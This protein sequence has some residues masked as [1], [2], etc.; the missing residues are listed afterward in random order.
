MGEMGLIYEPSAEVAALMYQRMPTETRNNVIWA[1]SPKDAISVLKDYRS[2]LV[3]V[4]LGTITDEDELV[5]EKSR[6]S[7][8]EIIR[9][10]QN[11][12]ADGFDHCTFYLHCHDE[13]T[14]EIM[15]DRLNGYLHVVVRPFGV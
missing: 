6:E 10:L 14:L 8:L 3:F 5:H 11:S 13:R 12:N 4:S 2:D 7:H 9:F 1:N 15:Q